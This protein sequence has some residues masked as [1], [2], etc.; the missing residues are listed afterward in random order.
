MLFMSAL[1]RQTVLP[2]GDS[3]S[4]ADQENSGSPLLAL[5]HGSSPRRSTSPS[6]SKSQPLLPDSALSALRSAV[7][8]KTLQLQ[9]MLLSIPEILPLR[10]EIEQMS[11]SDCVY[12]TSEVAWSPPSPQYSS[13]GSSFPRPIWPKE[14]QNS[15]TKVCRERGTLPRENR[16]PR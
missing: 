15:E 2:E 13:C 4:E 5:F 8:N 3:S 6:R 14:K 16:R 9:V 10:L 11:V 12:R 1:V 7:T